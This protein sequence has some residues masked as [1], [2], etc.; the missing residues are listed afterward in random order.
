M[1]SYHSQTVRSTSCDFLTPIFM[2]HSEVPVNIFIRMLFTK[3]RCRTAAWFSFSIYWLLVLTTSAFSWAQTPEVSLTLGSPDHGS[4]FASSGQTVTGSVTPVDATLTLD[5]QAVTVLPDGTFTTSVTLSPGLNTL[6][7]KADKTGYISA[8]RTLDLIWDQ[9]APSITI[10]SPDAGAY[11]NRLPLVVTGRVRD[12]HDHQLT[13]TRDGN[14]V[15]VTD[16][17]F[18]DTLASLATGANTFTYQAADSSGHTQTLDLTVHFNDQ[19][20]SITLQAPG[21]VEA[22]T[23]FD[24][25]VSAMPSSEIASLSLEVGNEVVYQAADGA[26]HTHAATLEAGSSQVTVQARARDIYGNARVA[27][28]TVHLARE[29]VVHGQVLLDATGEPL[30]GLTV[31]VETPTGVATPTT[32]ANGAY[33]VNVSGAPITVRLE[34][35][36]Y[37]PM[38]R[39]ELDGDPIWR[40]PDLRATALGATAPSG[41]TVTP[42]G[43]TGTPRLS[44]FGAQA[45][46][47]L[48]PLGWS[49]VAGFTLDQV[50]GTGSLT[51]QSS[52]RY[53]PP[54]ATFALLA[55]Q[56]DGWQVVDLQPSDAFD[57]QWDMAEAGSYL[58]AVAD[59]WAI[60]ATLAPGSTLRREQTQ[61]IAPGTAGDAQTD[62]AQVSILDNPQ[63]SLTHVVPTDGS[64]LSGSQTR[65]VTQERHQ[66]FH[67]PPTSETYA[68]DVFYY[69]YSHGDHQQ[70]DRLGGRLEV[71]AR[72]TVDPQQTERAT[73]AFKPGKLSD[74]VSETPGDL[75]WELP[76]VTLDFAGAYT[77][78]PIMDV[79]ADPAEG[80]P[81]IARSQLVQAFTYSATTDPMQAPLVTVDLVPSDAA[82]VI[83]LREVLSGW[84]YAGRLMPNADVWEGGPGALDLTAPGTYALVALTDAIT[85]LRGTV[86]RASQAEPDAMLRGEHIPWL[87]VSD[88]AGSY[89]YLVPQLNADQTVSATSGDQRHQGHLALTGTQGVSLLENQTVTLDPIGFTLIDHTPVDGASHA[90]LLPRIEL[91][92][93]LPL[94]EDESLL[95]A[96]ITLTDAGSNGVPLQILP[97]P[98]RQTLH[99]VPTQALT[100]ATTHTLSIQSG[101]LSW[102]GDPY[103]GLPSFQFTTRAATVTTPLDLQRFYL[104]WDTAT[105]VMTLVGPA[106]AYASGT[107]LEVFV[108]ASGYGLTTTLTSGEYRHEIEA[109]PG[110]MV[111]LVAVAPDGTTHRAS[112]SRVARSDGSM[113]L[114]TQPQTLALDAETD[115]EVGQVGAG[116]RKLFRI[117]A[118]TP[119][120]MTTF[121]DEVPSFEDGPIP[122]AI[123]GYALTGENG[124]ALPDISGQVVATLDPSAW[125]NG[126]LTLLAI[127]PDIM[128]PPDPT[129]PT[130]LQA[131]SFAYLMDV[132]VVLDGEVI[133]DGVA[134]APGGVR[135]PLR[136]DLGNATYPIT[137]Q[138]HLVLVHTP[139]AAAKQG[140]QTASKNAGQVP[141]LVNLRALRKNTEFIAPPPVTPAPWH[142]LALD[143]HPVP[144][145]I[146]Y[147]SLIVGGLP[148]VRVQGITGSNGEIDLFTYAPLGKLR[149]LDPATNELAYAG[150]G[151]PDSVNNIYGQAIVL[152]SVSRVLF[153]PTNHLILTG[154][155]PPPGLSVN[156]EVGIKSEGVFVPDLERTG[157]LQRR[158]KIQMGPSLV[159]RVT[160]TSDQPIGNTPG[161]SLST[162]GGSEIGPLEQE[163]Y[164]AIFEMPPET[165][166]SERLLVLTLTITNEGGQTTEVHRDVLVTGSSTPGTK[167]GP[168]VLIAH[169]PKDGA[170]VPIT[171]R[172]YL[173]FSEPVTGVTDQTVQLTRH[174]DPIDVQFRD[175]NGN[176]VTGT[177]AVTELFILPQQSLRL[178][179]TFQLQVSNLVDL[180]NIPMT[181]HQSTFHTSEVNL[182]SL[183][184]DQTVQDMA[185]YR[186][187]VLA[188][189]HDWAA[190]DMQLT[191]YDIRNPIEPMALVWSLPVD[192][193]FALR[194]RLALF[195]P[196]QLDPDRDPA[197]ATALRND[198]RHDRPLENLPVGTIAAVAF[199]RTNSA[200]TELILLTFDGT[201][202]EPSD[203]FPLF[204]FG[205][206]E[207][208]AALG[209]HLLIG[210]YQNEEV[211]ASS[212][213]GA[214]VVYDLPALIRDYPAL[215]QRY[216]SRSIT[217]L[218]FEQELHRVGI[219]AKYPLPGDVRQITPFFRKAGDRYQPAMLISGATR[220]AIYPFD[221]NQQPLALGVPVEA[222]NTP[223][224]NLEADGVTPKYDGRMLAYTDYPDGPSTTKKGNG[225]VEQ[226]TYLD[227]RTDTLK[228]SDFAIFSN[229][230]QDVG[231]LT[232]YELPE[233]LLP[234]HEVLDPLIH[235]TVPEGVASLAVEPELGFVAIT[236]RDGRFT[237]F[238]LRALLEGL[239]SNLV[240]THFIADGLN[241]PSVMV[242]PRDG[243]MDWL[244]FHQGNLFGGDEQNQLNRLPLA[245]NDFREAGW[246]VYDLAGWLNPVSPGEPPRHFT[247][248]LAEA[249]VL[250]A[251]DLVLEEGG[252]RHSKF[253]MELGTFDLEIRGRADVY[254]QIHALANGQPAGSP[255]VDIERLDVTGPKLEPFSTHGLADHFK[256]TTPQKALRASKYQA[257]R[258]S[259]RVLEGQHLAASGHSDFA[260]VYTGP[261]TRFQDGWRGMDSVDA[262]TL[263]PDLATVDYDVSSGLPSLAL[264]PSRVY[265]VGSAFQ[266]GGY[267]VGMLNGQ[268]LHM[269]MPSWWR[270]DKVG[271]G[272][273]SANAAIQRLMLTQPGHFHAQYQI[274]SDGSAQALD[275]LFSKFETKDGY[276]QLT[277]D[278]RVQYLFASGRPLPQLYDLFQK[279]NPGSGQDVKK[280]RFPLFRLASGPQA[281][282]QLY[283]EVPLEKQSQLI[284]ENTLQPSYNQIPSA[285]PN[286]LLET[287]ADTANGQRTLAWSY[288]GS[289]AG[290]VISKADLTTMKTM[291]SYAHDA[292]GYLTEVRIM[293]ERPMTY[294]W[295]SIGLTIGKLPIKRL[296]KIEQGN[297]F[298]RYHYEGPSDLIV[299]AI[300][301]PF[302]IETLEATFDLPQKNRP[303]AEETASASY[304]PKKVALTCSIPDCPTRTVHFG[305]VDGQWL[306]S[307]ETIGTAP[308]EI[309]FN[310]TWT[311]KT[312]GGR[313]RYLLASQ[314]RR[315]QSFSYD[316]RGRRTEH[317]QGGGVQSWT[318]HNE[319]GFRHIPKT[320]ID[321]EGQNFTIS[322][323]RNAITTTSGG[324]VRTLK[325]SGS[326]IPFKETNPLGLTF[327]AKGTAYYAP[328]GSGFEQALGRPKKQPLAGNRYFSSQTWQ[329]NAIGEL[330]TSSHMGAKTIYENYD[331][332]GRPGKITTLNGVATTFA[333]TYEGGL[334]KVT[335]TQGEGESALTQTSFY[336]ARGNLIRQIQAFGG[337]SV[338]K[339]YTYDVL[340][341]LLT[342]SKQAGSGPSDN[343]YQATYDPT[344][345]SSQPNS[346]TSDG[347]T[348]TYTL[349]EDYQPRIT[350]VQRIVDGK[351]REVKYA[352]DA[353]GRTIISEMEGVGLVYIAYD[354]FDR[355]TEILSLVEGKTTSLGRTN[356]YGPKTITINDGFSGIQTTVTYHDDAG[357]SRTVHQ[358]GNGLDEA[359]TRRYTTLLDPGA[360]L[361][362][363][364]SATNEQFGYAFIVKETGGLVEKT[365]SISATGHVLG[366]QYGNYAWHV[367]STE[368]DPFGNPKTIA[369]VA[370]HTMTYD[371]AGR[372][373]GLQD[374][375][376]LHAGFS[377]D[378]HFRLGGLTDT[379]NKPQTL[380]YIDASDDLKQVAIVG[381]NIDASPSVTTYSGS[382]TNSRTEASTETWQGRLRG[383]EETVLDTE[384]QVTKIHDLSEVTATVVQDP[385]SGL[386]QSITNYSG[387]Q[388]QFIPSNFGKHWDILTPNNETW[389]VDFDGLGQLREVRQGEDRK[390]TIR[391]DEENRIRSLD[392]GTLFFQ[393]IYD[394][395]DLTEIRG[396]TPILLS[397]HNGQGQAQT[398]E[399]GD[400]AKLEVGYH[401]NGT[402]Q[403]L[404]FG[405]LGG[406]QTQITTNTHGDLQTIT[407]D[408][409]ST[410]TFTTN[411]WGAPATM[412]VGNGPV[413][414]LFSGDLQTL[415]LPANVTATLD[416]EGRIKTID[417]AGVAIL[418]IGYDADDRPTA[419]FLGDA[420]SEEYQYV[421]GYLYIK[422]THDYEPV[423][424]SKTGQNHDETQTYSR[425]GRGRITQ[426]DST[427]DGTSSYD[428]VLADNATPLPEARHS[429]RLKTYTDPNGVVYRYDY[430]G[431]GYVSR[432]DI[433]NG[434][435]FANTYDPAGN[436]LNVS[437]DAMAA[438]FANYQRGLPSD[439]SWV[440]E[441][442]TEQS[443]TLTRTTNGRFQEIA[444]GDYRLTLE[445][446]S[447]PAFGVS[448]MPMITKMTKKGPG[449]KE[450]WEP[451]YD[452]DERLTGITI[453]RTTGSD[454][455]ADPACG[456]CQTTVIEETYG[457]MNQLMT[458]L[459]R[460]V[461]GIT[462]LDTSHTLDPSADQRRIGERQA[463]LDTLTLDYDDLGSI[464][465]MA[466]S[467]TVSQAFDLDGT[468]RPRE[469]HTTTSSGTTTETFGYDTQN[470]RIS[471]D[472][473]GTHRIY[474]H[475]GSRVIAMGTQDADGLVTWTHAFGHGP[476]GPV[477]IRDL[478]EGGNDAFIFSD[479]LGTPFAY[480]NPVTDT[481][482]YTPFNPWGELLATTASNNPPWA[483]QG[484]IPTTGFTLAPDSTDTLPPLGL[485]GHLYDRE[486]GLVQMHHRYYSPRLGHFLTP[487]YRAPDIYDPS[488]FT[489]P[490]AYAAGNPML[491][492]D[493]DGL[494]VIYLGDGR[495]KI[496]ALD[497][498]GVL[499]VLYLPQEHWIKLVTGQA[500][501]YGPYTG[502]NFLL[503]EG[504][505]DLNTAQGRAEYKARANA[506]LENFFGPGTEITASHSDTN[507]VIVS[508]VVNGSL[509]AIGLPAGASSGFA[510]V[511]GLSLTAEAGLSGYAIYDG[512]GNIY[513]GIQDGNAGQV[514]WGTLETAAGVL[515]GYGSVRAL[516][517]EIR[518]GLGSGALVVDDALLNAYVA[519][520]LGP[521]AQ[522]NRLVV[523]NNS[524][525]TSPSRLIGSGESVPYAGGYLR[526]FTLEKDKIF[527]RVFSGDRNVGGFLTGVKPKNSAFAQEGLSLPRLN[528]AEFIQEVFVPAGTRLQRSR[529][530]PMRT[531]NS[532]FPNRRGGLEQFE[533]LDR[534]AIENFGPGV[535]FK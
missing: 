154:Q 349:A 412:Q 135:V 461:D 102:A 269:A 204:G 338:T 258:L 268:L 32:D 155:S 321:A 353:L 469:I 519:E 7:F 308:S 213:G 352:T 119:T 286:Q 146:V 378:D 489:E 527:F 375:N 306:S 500:G 9:T 376:G 392:T 525:I 497:I 395:P 459:T 148:D 211:V 126:F 176:A 198:A 288:S 109:L 478:T 496:E 368:R 265:H 242:T 20:P 405:N 317:V 475:H 90:A 27:S 93:N 196:D 377:Y 388:F 129:Q 386:L 515:G 423:G 333:Y 217:P 291:L 381:Q 446:S 365:S 521:V 106:T 257:F 371:Q 232:I 506:V 101:L 498:Y 430:N 70:P 104:E 464:T 435:T 403:T 151:D 382:P 332:R 222:P 328:S 399:I 429:D 19:A 477:F 156:W 215:L 417:K 358:T 503:R 280:L 442:Q 253:V 229:Y 473:G 143:A 182:E 131:H 160:A 532:I 210:Y 206:P 325:L 528:T 408:G 428:Y 480:H 438:S 66:Y 166:T 175:Q 17:G 282:G 144:G 513:E 462:V 261:Q 254:V 35:G 279:A 192:L 420:T 517:G 373:T 8:V 208:T 518:A 224:L 400:L 289:V 431:E 203:P 190:D 379:R 393:Y 116:A 68:F 422:L 193:R 451:V 511:R 65:M 437:V 137:D 139:S 240:G 347:V 75:V 110:D 448:P 493:P 71:R 453:T 484:Q 324:A 81:L 153:D 447:D 449:M 1:P 436:L 84:Q 63:T 161:P 130:Q 10:T 346:E 465:A 508:T 45:L 251:S 361:P 123:R 3:Y 355:I 314:S 21:Q 331:D 531:P 533:L 42:S 303:K 47:D 366:S 77:Q 235:M 501:G 372:L 72:R 226:L 512:S 318:Y 236:T 125:A 309:T 195:T 385:Q 416:R 95:A 444:N 168:P 524:S 107:S 80:L 457:S 262:L 220:P 305:E 281:P 61:A 191:L 34:D 165:L 340:G 250:Y 260:V 455:D 241:D 271:T 398:I 18:T 200:K 214:T 499:Q 504:T 294:T 164:R 369:G 433:E 55:Q 394:G 94:T 105:E 273:P 357:W 39:H 85:E 56:D 488:T 319:A 490:Y 471:R 51:W 50:T 127:V 401:P 298:T 59:A 150:L 406:R 285:R 120:E 516:T 421:D 481:T 36:G 470:R 145:T 202:F 336:S 15:P 118:L 48:L 185:G 60:T 169:S 507:K 302:G 335:Q 82:E 46:P 209:R 174:G 287:V 479:H 266:R 89:R 62:P 197:E 245:P 456:D 28:A 115:L 233:S 167:P 26:T 370:P 348:L 5:G 534:I 14:P 276:W 223:G 491:Y 350:A 231:S 147:Q 219:V 79:V 310:H 113:M 157:T 535:P 133:G 487:D 301:T 205:W 360:V 467:T 244:R 450:V 25:T 454:V 124:A 87:G 315:S 267:G 173:S 247:P 23:A 149:A 256:A 359:V 313:S 397:N 404:L 86:M 327:G 509:L 228:T 207:A 31:H 413:L 530:L 334:Y 64:T 391:R 141:R 158:N 212:I 407:R 292:D 452:A 140:P 510:F 163:S 227:P 440:Y 16:G 243:N 4:L 38:V 96:N 108:D 300:E 252:T 272:V 383:V 474:A 356:T 24:I 322:A 33:Q 514:V 307:S 43:F 122:T 58:V 339:E 13:L 311:R 255:V 100:A 415:H 329:P 11:L 237:V 76:G 277:Q 88:A 523:Q 342:I 49:P 320:F 432:I 112:I 472:D 178:D 374:A 520:S 278:D 492:W 486:T 92:F 297:W 414:E 249:V 396:A 181:A 142:I 316:E 343:R 12:T 184:F 29:R 188:L 225:A 411:E 410:L 485:A 53:L 299:S 54:G 6:R 73:L 216:Q 434:P 483:G 162:S 445:W 199:Q 351:G 425:D 426:I 117:D 30:A 337:A 40:V 239:P 78:T 466:F 476:L 439:V 443:F 468:R 341:R 69:S 295:A 364:V 270:L 284:W 234:T 103:D 495:V 172:P 259:Y 384:I 114:G 463:G 57:F 41:M 111:R 189:I 67:Q 323:T 134:T 363:I 159:L 246:E 482:T 390:L 187:L 502:E 248:K 263:M 183:V 402:P 97:A 409:Q 152:S 293:D 218:E 83:L 275:D 505:P 44:F 304:L 419:K 128:V 424:K 37:V 179:A 296:V 526:S 194:Y 380:S 201:S 91:Q 362:G 494:A 136:F 121:L 354:S 2:H 171:E 458:G 326:G 389:Q 170:T 52:K 238:E 274:E 330:E 290:K 387:E 367:P 427:L 98:G 312:N 345:L 138:A 132:L 344:N 186:N 522:R 283:A 99:L 180:N 74:Q 221:L 177:D 441:S 460:I 529:A 264:S 418:A 22:S 230:Y